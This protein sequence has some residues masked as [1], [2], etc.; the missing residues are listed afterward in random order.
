VDGVLDT[1]APRLDVDQVRRLLLTHWGVEAGALHPL[2]SERDLNVLVDDR[3]VL[4]VPM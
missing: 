2:P 3:Y 1:P 4:K